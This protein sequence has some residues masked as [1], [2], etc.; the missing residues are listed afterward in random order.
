MLAMAPG[1]ASAPSATSRPHDSINDGNLPIVIQSAMRQDMQ[2]SPAADR[3]AII[4]RVA[5]L[6]TRADAAAYLAEVAAKRN[7]AAPQAPSP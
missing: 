7:A 1:K 3:N 4:A 6:K 5:T 2:L